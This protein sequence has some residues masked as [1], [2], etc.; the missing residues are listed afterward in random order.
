[1][2]CIECRISQILQRLAKSVKRICHKTENNYPQI[3]INDNFNRF[4]T[5]YKP[6]FKS[7]NKKILQLA[8]WFSSTEIERLPIKCPL[9]AWPSSGV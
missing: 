5:K 8:K 6:K 3:A 9:N 2:C 1:M 7:D 4:S